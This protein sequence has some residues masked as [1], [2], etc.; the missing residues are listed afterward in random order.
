MNPNAAS[1]T[2]LMPIHNGMTESEL[3][4]VEERMNPVASQEIYLHLADLLT[5]VK[6]IATDDRLNILDFGA[7]LSPYR[8]LFPNSDYRRADIGG[9]GAEDYLITDGGKV[10]ERD[11]SFD[12]I[13]STQVAEHL[14]DPPVYFD[15][16]FRLLKPG[17]RLFLSTHGSF[18]DHSFPGDF[19]RWTAE[20]LKRDLGKSGFEILKAYRMTAGPRA[21]LH[22][23]E[24]CLE[25]TFPSRA[26]ATGM[27]LWLLRGLHRT[28][29]PI[30]NRIADNA[31]SAYKVI[32]VASVSGDWAR[33][34]YIGVAVIARRPGSLRIS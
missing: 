31:F 14:P 4:Y 13:L 28:F 19:Q 33:N 3:E 17:G 2:G 21:A 10:G 22:H 25:T 5:T 15:E 6:T 27:T 9:P 29:R 11:E 20:G 34:M 7:N 16:C 26:T 30:I 18:E 23:V 24:R 12:L 8:T 1:Q 32:D